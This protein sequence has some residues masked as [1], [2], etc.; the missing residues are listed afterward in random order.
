M[1]TERAKKEQKEGEGAQ[2]TKKKTQMK[3]EKE[4]S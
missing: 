4:R 1:W 2:K 3:E